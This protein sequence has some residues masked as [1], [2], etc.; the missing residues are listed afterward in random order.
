MMHDKKE[1]M[2]KKT[3]GS[4]GKN[5]KKSKAKRKLKKGRR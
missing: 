5:G 3:M 1:H 2:M 4:K